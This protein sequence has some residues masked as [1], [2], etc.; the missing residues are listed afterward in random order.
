MGGDGRHEG[1]WQRQAKRNKRNKEK[2]CLLGLNVQEMR[3]KRKSC[4][5]FKLNSEKSSAH[6]SVF[7]CPKA[8]RFQ[9]TPQSHSSP[10]PSPARS[11]RLAS[12]RQILMV[13]KYIYKL[14]GNHNIVGNQIIGNLLTVKSALTGRNPRSPPPPR[15]LWNY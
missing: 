14:K 15:L 1:E 8:Q 5:V 7:T 11:K 3:R 4:H 6:I 12:V 9:R 10:S 2:L 13:L